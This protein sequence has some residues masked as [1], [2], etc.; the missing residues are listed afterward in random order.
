M[1]GS[2]VS[3]ERLCSKCG[4]P[5]QSHTCYCNACYAAYNQGRR[6]RLR[7]EAL[8]AAGFV[9][10]TKLCS[11]CGTTKDISA[12]PPKTS[13]N[14]ARSARCNE[15]GKKAIRAAYVPKPRPTPEERF[16]KHV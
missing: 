12:F 2:S 16:W 3:N 5:R 4:R 7:T 6:L 14:P 15:C 9:D 11:A 1:D 8:R 13:K 10:G